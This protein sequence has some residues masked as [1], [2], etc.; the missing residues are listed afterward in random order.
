MTFEEYTASTFATDFPIRDDRES[1]IAR[2]V[3]NAAVKAE[4]DRCV[5]ELLRT[6]ERFVRW[7]SNPEY[8][9]PEGSDAIRT[10]AEWLKEGGTP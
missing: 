1:I 6:A 4:R 10:A 3:W 7:E 9:H 5:A 2:D 8:D